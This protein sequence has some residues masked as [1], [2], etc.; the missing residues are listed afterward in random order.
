MDT[1]MPKAALLSAMETV[2]SEWE[3]LL[4]QLDE[5]ALL[6]PGVE[7]VWSVK[8]IVAHIA[9]YE[10]YAAALL[11][12]R[13]DPGAGAQATLDAFY[14]QQLNEYRHHRPDFPAQMSETDDDQT[15]A[16]VVA[17]YDRYSAHTVLN[18]EHQ[19]YQQLLA[20]I[21]AVSDTQLTEPWRPNGRSLL[22]ILPN[23]SYQ[24]YQTHMPAI[25]RWLEQRQQ[26]THAES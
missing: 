4:A 21:R 10:E 16:L 8:Q 13:L 19:A 1:P 6:E 18:R 3:T 25:R 26:K 11:T 5:Q 14:Q 22:E 2:R 17:V 20:A 7:G 9:G 24:H 23:Q 12:D 15:N